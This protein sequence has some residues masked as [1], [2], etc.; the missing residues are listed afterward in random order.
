MVVRLGTRRARGAPASA[1]CLSAEPAGLALAL[2]WAFPPGAGALD[3]G[4]PVPECAAVRA[5]HATPLSLTAHRGQIVL[6]D[7][8]TSWCTPCRQAMPFYDTLYRRFRD[9]GFEIVAINVDEDADEAYAFLAR[10]PVTFE[11]SFDPRGECPQRYGLKVMPSSYLV[12][13]DGRLQAVHAG[14]RDSEAA[15][16]ERDVERLLAP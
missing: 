2:A 6:V 10:H 16:I 7:F 13:R 14:F 11:S 5:D 1:P 3:P 12:D 15:A 8:W 4:Q 9:R